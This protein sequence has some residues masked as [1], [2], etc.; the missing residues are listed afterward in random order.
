MA[1]LLIK[2]ARCKQC[3]LCAKFCPKQALSYPTETI[4]EAG[5]YPV[6]VDK[7]ACIACG[8]CYAM[9]PDGV[10]AITDHD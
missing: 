2:K 1:E 4:N 5:Y 10:F 9:C 6:A 7:E 3:G 8:I